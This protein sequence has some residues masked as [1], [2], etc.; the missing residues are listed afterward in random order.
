MF[1]E[2]DIE[3]AVIGDQEVESALEDYVAE[4]QDELTSDFVEGLIDKILVFQDALVGH[5]LHEYQIP[6]ARRI[7][8]SVIVGDGDLITALASRQSGKSETV[9][10]V[11]ASLMVVLPQLAKVYPDLLGKFKN[12][13]WVG[14]FAPVEGQ[15]ETL[16]GRA[17]TRLTS[18]RAQEVLGDPE[19][20]DVTGRN[21][22]VTKGIRLKKSG[23][24][25]LMMT[26]NPRAKIESKTFH[27]VILDEAQDAD[28]YVVS[29]SISPMMAYTAGT[30]VMTGTPTRSKNH[31]YR[32]IQLNKRLQAGG[33]G[34]KRN[35]FEWNWRA[36]A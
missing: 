8:H 17:V 34:K 36:V 10:D 18:D 30:M 13:F 29:K 9:A 1:D 11:V 2:E 15:A 28:D 12:G 32:S 23:S 4:E 20:D 14:M 3:D 24:T 6:L 7:I 25:M 33:R 21:P 19:I 35:H 16:F 31:F 5:S 22:G 27:L 26:A